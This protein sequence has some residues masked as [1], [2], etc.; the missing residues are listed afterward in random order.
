MLDYKQRLKDVKR[1]LKKVSDSRNFPEEVK[2][3]RVASLR[4]QIESLEKRV[5]KIERLNK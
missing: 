4:E 3:L 1:R 5:A 2:A